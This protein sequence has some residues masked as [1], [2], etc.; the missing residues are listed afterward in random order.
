MPELWPG[1]P[2]YE[3]GAAFPITTDSVLLA[4]FAAVKPGM[5]VLEPGCGA[6]LISLLLLDREPGIRVQAVELDEA[7]ACAARRNFSVNGFSAKAE[8]ICGDLRESASLPEAN[9]CDLVVCNPPYFSAADGKLSPDARRALA[10]SEMECTLADV[11]RAAGRSLRQGG[12]FA[13]VYRPEQLAALFAAL[14]AERLEPKRLRFVHHSVDKPA[15]IVLCEAV[16]L[17]KPGIRV[18]P[19]LLLNGPDVRPSAEFKRIYHLG[20]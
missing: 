15:G 16:R 4:A 5:R 14:S 11:A 3:G 9:S 7:A 10:R 1:G 12:R 13:I 6:G 2:E 20:G 19:P 17:G 18:E 8:V